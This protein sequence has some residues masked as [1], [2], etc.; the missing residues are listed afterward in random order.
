MIRGK[1]VDAVVDRI[2]GDYAV[3]VVGRNAIDWPVDLLPDGVTEGSTVRL[4]AVPGKKPPKA[5]GPEHI[6][7]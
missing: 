5:T 2:E 6:E 1:H 4:T 7:L 3:L